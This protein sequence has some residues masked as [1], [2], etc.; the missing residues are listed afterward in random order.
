MLLGADTL[1]RSVFGEL[2]ELEEENANA[3]GGPNG[4]RHQVPPGFYTRKVVKP[5]HATAQGAIVSAGTRVR[6]GVASGT[7][8]VSRDGPPVVIIGKPTTVELVQADVVAVIDAT[9][10]KTD[11]SC[12]VQL[13]EGKASVDYTQRNAQDDAFVLEFLV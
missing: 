5:V 2:P 9:T 7:E 8:H 11:I 12:F 4:Q 6:A 3:G 1:G 10:N 13:L